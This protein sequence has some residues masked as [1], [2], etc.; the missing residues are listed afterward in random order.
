VD[1]KIEA[2]RVAARVVG[3]RIYRVTIAI[4]AVTTKRWQEIV[5][6]STGRI[7][8]LVGLLRGELPDEVMQAVTDRQAGLFPRPR[9]MQM[10]CDCPDSAG[11]CK[12][13]AAALY[14]VGAR[15]DDQPELLF[16]L[17]G[18]DPKDLVERAT[19]GLASARKTTAA[20][21]LPAGVEELGALFGIELVDAPSGKAKGSRAS[22]RAPTKR[23]RSGG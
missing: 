5:R 19:A 6:T 3:T 20:S 10:S 12:H 1:L 11:L 8:S 2:G 7:S 17:R 15:L 9:E 18:V 21:T 23:R 22:R 13:L 4:E 16:R 14:G